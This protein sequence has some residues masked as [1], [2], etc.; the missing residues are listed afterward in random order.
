[1]TRLPECLLRLPRLE[2]LDLSGNFEL[3]HLPDD[4]GLLPLVVLDLSW[5]G[6]RTLPASLQTTTTL[7]VLDVWQST[8]LCGPSRDIRTGEVYLSA[9]R[10]CLKLADAADEIARIDAVLRPLSL[11]L[12]ALR[13]R[14]HGDESTGMT[15]KGAPCGGWWHARCGHD[16]TDPVFF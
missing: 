6:V 7:R 2:H 14:M 16:W 4:L 3:E 10:H 12:P 8:W 11:A 15:P 1:M 9:D 5:T 13:I